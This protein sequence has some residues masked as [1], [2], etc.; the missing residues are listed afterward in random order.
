MLELL[1]PRRCVLCRT[2]GTA[3]CGSCATSLPAAPDLAA[4][5]GLADCWSLLTYEGTTK[6]LVA[7]LKFHNHRDAAH[8]LGA[9][10]ARLVDPDLVTRLDVITWAPTTAGRRRRRGYDQAELLARSVAQRLGLPCRSTLERSAGAAQAGH[11]REER[12]HGPQFR[13]RHPAPARVVLVDDVRTTGATLC[14]AA[15]TLTGAG[16]TEVVGLTLAVTLGPGQA[17]T[18]A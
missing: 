2:E 4:P 13:S 9:A 3:L 16:A 14:S 15:D 8:L 17:A 7:A 5:P 10:M 12:L 1:M 18:S 6:D 11:G